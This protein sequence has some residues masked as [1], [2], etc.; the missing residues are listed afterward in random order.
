[1]SPSLSPEMDSRSSAVA[2][3]FSVGPPCSEVSYRLAGVQ[4]SKHT[5]E[6]GA[7][8]R[9]RP[10]SGKAGRH[11]L[12]VRSGR[13]D[14]H[15]IMEAGGT[16]KHKLALSTELVHDGEDLIPAK[17]RQPVEQRIEGARALPHQ[18]RS[19]G[20]LDGRRS[21]HGS[22]SSDAQPVGPLSE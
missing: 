2:R 10:S 9:Q 6:I 18:L 14:R 15:F 13:A 17:L 20:G 22:L 8:G 21:Q 3:G 5:W 16:T 4:L 1:M 7:N 12:S 11:W 19:N